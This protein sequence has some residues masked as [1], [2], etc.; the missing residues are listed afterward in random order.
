MMH[1]SFLVIR[2]NERCA[3]FK[4]RDAAEFYVN[5]MKGVFAHLDIDWE[6]T[7]SYVDGLYW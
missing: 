3:Y 2:N 6:I 7:E 4:T 1:N 5:L